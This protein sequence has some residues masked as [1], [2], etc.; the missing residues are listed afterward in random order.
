[1]VRVRTTSEE[2]RASRAEPAES[3]PESSAAARP[4]GKRLCRDAV[5]EEECWWAWQDSNLQPRDS[6]GPAV[7]DG[8]G[9]SL[10]PRLRRLDSLRVR[11]ALACYQGRSRIRS[12]ALR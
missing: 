6:L 7:S 1:M 3:T 9:L 12:A 10:H 2:G 5:A 11:D 4:A 8:S